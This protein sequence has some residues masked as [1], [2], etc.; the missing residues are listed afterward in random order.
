VQYPESFANP[1][2]LD[3][4]DFSDFREKYIISDFPDFRINYI[5]S[6]FPERP[7]PDNDLGINV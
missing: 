7:L 4:F 2:F 5:I 3:L 6:D 1:H